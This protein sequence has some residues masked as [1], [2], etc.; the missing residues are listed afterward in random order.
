VNAGSTAA[1]I[2]GTFSGGVLRLGIQQLTGAPVELDCGGTPDPNNADRWIGGLR[3]CTRGGTGVA[4]A[5]GP[6]PPFPGPPGGQLDADGDGF[7]SLDPALEPGACP[8]CD[9]TAFFLK[10]GA[11]PAEIKTGDLVI[12]RVAAEGGEREITA[13]VPYVIAT[14]P[15]LASYRDTAGH[16]STL[17]YPVGAGAPGT[18]GNGFPVSAPAGQ[19]VMLTLTLWRPQRRA[20]PDSDPPSA[21]WM[22]IGHLV[23]TAYLADRG[24]LDGGCPQ[25]AF[26]TTDPN[27]SPPTMPLIGTGGLADAEGDEASNPAN[28]FTYTL[29]LSQCLAAHGLSFAPGEEYALHFSSVAGA[30]DG[31][32]QTVAF[33][34]E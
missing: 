12:E 24:I 9:P 25:G 30:T 26:S 16:S 31:A 33:K 14:V 22:D 6:G 29:N 4:S 21:E 19:D 1:Q 20:I 23:H 13:T 2:D 7:G 28:T 32:E 34:R 15:A 10:H 17:S 11:G 8:G 18:R 5:G 27:L 3:Y